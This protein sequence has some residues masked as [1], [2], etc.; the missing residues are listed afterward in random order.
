[1]VAAANAT[2]ELPRLTPFHHGLSP[3]HCPQ[4]AK[5]HGGH[6]V[7]S[8]CPW[9][10]TQTH[11]FAMNTVSGC[12]GPIAPPSAKPLTALF[13][14]QPLASSERTSS[15]APHAGRDFRHVAPQQAR[16][17][18]P[19]RGRVGARSAPGWGERDDVRASKVP[20]RIRASHKVPHRRR[21]ERPPHFESRRCSRTE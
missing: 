17:T 14:R 11:C 20:A 13:F 4:S 1:M 6:F 19:W 18:L 5:P 8:A 15:H 10:R 21:P 9:L 12:R 16:F 2:E 3:F 7:S